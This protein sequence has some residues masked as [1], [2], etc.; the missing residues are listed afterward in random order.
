[1]YTLPK[2]FPDK[3]CVIQ[4]LI[5][6]KSPRYNEYHRAQLGF[7]QIIWQ[8][9]IRSYISQDKKIKAGNPANYFAM[10]QR[11][12]SAQGNPPPRI[13]AMNINIESSVPYRK[14]E[15][16]KLVTTR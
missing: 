3:S 15:T 10:V 1:M 9:V 2:C 8:T 6:I 12:S 4:K 7:P 11:L 13:S 5:N 14:I 16:D